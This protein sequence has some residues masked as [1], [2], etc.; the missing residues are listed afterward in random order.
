MSKFH[1]N[2]YLFLLIAL[3]L[4]LGVTPR[5]VAQGE[6]DT[7]SQEAMPP[8]FDLDNELSVSDL[9]LKLEETNRRLHEIDIEQ[10]GNRTIMTGFDNVASIVSSVNRLSTTIQQQ[11]LAGLNLNY[12]RNIQNELKRYHD[13]LQLWQNQILSQA[14]KLSRAKQD[15]LL[16][17]DSFS[18]SEELINDTT[19]TPLFQEQLQNVLNQTAGLKVRLD[20][21][22]KQLVEMQNSMIA[23]EMEISNRLQDIE[24]YGLNYSRSLLNRQSLVWT[25]PAASENYTFGKELFAQVG[26]GWQNVV[27]YLRDYRSGLYW[28]IIVFVA[29]LL[30]LKRLKVKAAELNKNTNTPRLSKVLYVLERPWASAWLFTVVLSPLFYLHPPIFFIQVTLV[31]QLIP[32]GIIVHSRKNRLE[33]LSYSLISSAYVLSELETVILDNSFGQRAMIIVTASLAIGS[34]G[35]LAYKSFSSKT[36]YPSFFKWAFMGF[37]AVYLI[38]IVSTVI[39]YIALG[40]MLIHATTLS[41]ILGIVIFISYRILGALILLF[42]YSEHIQRNLVMRAHQK[43]ISDNLF[44]FAGALMLLYWLGITLK[45]FGLFDTVY[46]QTRD[47]LLLPRFIGTFEFTLWSIVAFLLVVWLSVTL[48]RLVKYLLEQRYNNSTTTFGSRRGAYILLTRYFILLFGF[49]LAVVAAEIPLDKVTIILGALSVG[50][51]FGLQNIVNNLV[52]GLILALE[53]PIQTGDVIEVGEFLGVVKDIGIRS[54]TVT[55]LDGADV[56]VPNADFISS[57]VINWTHSNQS[58]RTEIFVGVAY[59]SKDDE[60]IKL[61]QETLRSHDEVLKTPEPMILF[62][63]FGESSIRFRLLFWVGNFKDWLRL[64][65]EIT[66]EIYRRLAEANIRIPF[67][68]RDLHIIDNSNHPNGQTISL[69]KKPSADKLA[70]D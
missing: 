24:Y 42:I 18:N 51:G 13:R 33:L 45:N 52:S 66:Q 37:L 41:I 19:L 69:E 56:I 22:L 3:T 28:Q 11:N 64:R 36:A 8:A 49:F 38:S 23:T 6:E 2:G 27:N 4:L 63:E 7:S 16:I 17:E 26:R 15:V 43:T 68:Q 57:K 54:S 50:I 30:I 1:T 10:V 59:G 14:E 44:Q 61:L 21:D 29:I 35:V 9:I 20:N 65:S 12:L 25:H 58:R 39:G 60:V 47:Y 34:L 46:E 53:R 40:S 32:L 48:S 67:P 70:P 5:V 31:L 55:T 62:H